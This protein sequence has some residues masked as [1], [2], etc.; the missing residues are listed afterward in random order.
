MER[1]YEVLRDAEFALELLEQCESD[2]RKFRILFVACLALLRTTGQVLVHKTADPCVKKAAL[3][4][5]AEHKENRSE[6][7]IYFDFVDAERGLIVHEYI[8]SLEEN[9]IEVVYDTDSG[10]L[11]VFNLD[12]LYRPLAD[13][14]TFDGQDIHDLIKEAIKWWRV[15]LEIIEQRLS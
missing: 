15:Q 5:F 12:D 13:H 2:M 1:S 3:D 7:K 9:D 14:E 11:G 8:I 6:H 4:L 10:D